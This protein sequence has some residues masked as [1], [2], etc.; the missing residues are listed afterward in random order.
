MLSGDNNFEEAND[1]INSLGINWKRD[2]YRGVFLE[3][4][5]ALVAI[6]CS[7]DE[8]KAILASLY[9]ASIKNHSDF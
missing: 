4:A 3:Q 1:I 2:F 7:T 9:Y 8:V 5:R 6:G